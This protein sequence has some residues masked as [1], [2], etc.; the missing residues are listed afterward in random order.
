MLLSS[1]KRLIWRVICSPHRCFGKRCASAIPMGIFLI[2]LVFV[3][4][5]ISFLFFVGRNLP[6]VGK[7]F[8]LPQG[9]GF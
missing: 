9:R 4:P 5:K 8:T 6:T 7:I 1:R 2:F 3:F